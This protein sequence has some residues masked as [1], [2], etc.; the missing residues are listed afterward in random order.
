MKK[1]V[2]LCGPIT[3]LTYDEARHGWRK[4]M[5]EALYDNG[6]G[7]LSPMR[8]KDHLSHEK[9]TMSAQGYGWSAMSNQKGITAR[10][11]FDT[12]RSDVVVCNL[13]GADRV[14]IGSM[15]ELGWADANRIPIVLVM[16]NDDDFFAGNK[17]NIHDHAM[18]KELAGFILPTVDDAID[19]VKALLIPGI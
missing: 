12:C 4:N 14:S 3:G 18:V 16:E 1:L 6:I 11:R 9:D 19:V 8:M 10:D 13:L 2:Y 15:I 17:P 5:F 7:C